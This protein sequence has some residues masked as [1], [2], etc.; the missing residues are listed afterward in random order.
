MKGT[1]LAALAATA[2][3]LAAC[4]PTQYASFAG[5]AIEMTRWTATLAA[6]S[7]AGRAG[8]V[9]SP[10]VTGTATVMPGD[11]ISLTRATLRIS[12]A[13]PGSSYPW[14][15]HLGRCGEDKGIV[16][17]SSMY[18]PVVVGADGR[19]EATVILPYTTPNQGEFFVEVHPPGR[20][21]GVV[22]CGNLTMSGMGR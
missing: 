18:T 2:I 13:T 7:G 8:S 20:V 11:S 5:G 1:H 22:A 6:P 4:A 3:A 14:H 10:S 9:T 21:S 15:V 16:G 19:G 12:G 17:I